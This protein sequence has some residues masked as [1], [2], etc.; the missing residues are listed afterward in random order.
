MQS[1]FKKVE[2]MIK[3]KNDLNLKEFKVKGQ[4][5]SDGFKTPDVK[6]LFSVIGNYLFMIYTTKEFNPQDKYIGDSTIWS[7][8]VTLEDATT[9]PTLVK[10]DYDG[11]EWSVPC[12]DV[13]KD[14]TRN[15]F[16]VNMQS[17]RYN[18]NHKRD[19]FKNLIHYLNE[20][21]RVEGDKRIRNHLQQ[22]K[23]A[24]SDLKAKIKSNSLADNIDLITKMSNL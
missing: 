22:V 20:I 15:N 7:I 13:T 11:V 24:E 17:S 5:F 8:S 12:Y 21:I 9:P 16:L 2:T 1:Q 14:I 18:K 23:K 3:T 10:N 4:K 19:G 6:Y